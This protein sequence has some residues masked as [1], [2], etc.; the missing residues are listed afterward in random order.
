VS[1]AAS[2]IY[3]Q[4][5]VRRVINAAGTKTV[6]G[7]SLMPQ[8]VIDAMADAARSFVRLR[9]LQEKAGQRIADLVGV[10]AAVVS[11]G[12]AGGI[13]LATAACVAGTDPRKIADLPNVADRNEVVV[14]EEG[15]N[16]IYQAAAAAGGRLVQVGGPDHLGADDFAGAIGDRTAAVLLVVYM[17]DR[18]RGRGAAGATVAAVAEVARSRGVPL[19]VDAAGELPPTS[20]FRRFLQ[21]GAD[22][23]VFSGGKA[24]R[25]PQCSGVV[26]GRPDLIEAC[27]ANGNPNS[28]IGRSCKVGKEEIAGLVRAVEMYVRRDEAAEMSRWQ[29]RMERMA[30]GLADLP[31]VEAEAAP[32]R[33]WNRPSIVPGCFVR[34]D[35]AR[36]RLTAAEVVE[37]L[38]A[39][40]PPIVVSTYPQGLLVNP[41]ELSP[42]DDE[43]VGARLRALLSTR[44][45]MP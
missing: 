1:V 35:D 30:A 21:E 32:Q 19:I 2:G 6:L 9:D 13:L 24:L 44:G 43:I 27:H 42:D 40:D 37:Q 16:Y 10:E 12:A 5:G 22:L 15:Q 18:R 20:N 36:A 25:G 29:E 45:E 38:D 33:E 41:I 31:G 17:L 39:G 4:L 28:A 34:I 11:S 8:P 14:A 7:G 26:V 23:V 3:E